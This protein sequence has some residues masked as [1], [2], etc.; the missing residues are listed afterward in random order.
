MIGSIA[1]ASAHLDDATTGRMRAVGPR[2]DSAAAG[3]PGLRQLA[4]RSALCATLL[5]LL[6]AA[7]QPTPAWSQATDKVSAPG[8]YTGYA[9]PLYDAWQRTSFHVPVRDGV[10]LAVDLYRPTKDGQP[11]A[12]PH[13]V[14][15]M[16]TPYQRG[17]KAPDGSVQRTGTAY[18]EPRDLTRYGYVVAIVDTRGKGASFG[19]RRGMQD[20]TE[21]RDA[22]DMTE[23]F[24]RQ[25]W[26]DGKV[27]S[28]LATPAVSRSSATADSKRASRCATGSSFSVMP[29]TDTGPG[30]TITWSAV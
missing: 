18:L 6:I 12:T 24:A 29:A 22:Y 7:A 30:I 4:P 1:Q 9:T 5:G 3:R 27:G 11:V 17:V 15:L 10:R 19:W 25:P 14:L 13:P 23:W 16:H 2:G 26:S 28:T 21:G 8:R 20:S